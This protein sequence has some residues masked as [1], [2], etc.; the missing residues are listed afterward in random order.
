MADA[1][2]SRNVN[3]PDGDGNGGNQ[4]PGGLGTPMKTLLAGAVLA[5]VV[6]GVTGVIENMFSATVDYGKGLLS[7]NDPAGDVPITAQASALDPED[8]CGGGG[9][10]VYLKPPTLPII[11]QEFEKRWSPEHP[12]YYLDSKFNARHEAKAANYT[13]VNLLIQGKGTEAVTIKNVKI[14]PVKVQPAP[15]GLRLRILGQCGDANMSRFS[16]DLDAREP[17]LKFKDGR[18]DSGQERKSGFP[19]R[20]TKGDPE[21]LVVVP[22]TNVSHYRFKLLVEWETG[23]A[24]GVLEVGD[25]KRD[26]EP[27]EVVAGLPSPKYMIQPDL[28]IL[29]H[30]ESRITD[31][32]ELIDIPSED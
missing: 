6:G 31:P 12:S 32:F 29:P 22:V 15:K 24:S 3:E 17:R 8:T 23:D 30:K 5:G 13:I 11:K 16:V 20:V 28:K 27:F 7:P 18:N 26:S 14:K 9:G 2:T 10:V 25:R 19:Y 4:P 21:S 1:T